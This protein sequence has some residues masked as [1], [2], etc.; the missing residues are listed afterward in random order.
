MD[1]VADLRRQRRAWWMSAGALRVGAAAAVL[2]AIL[3]ITAQEVAISRAGAAVDRL[4]G[5]AG[6]VNAAKAAEDK[7]AAIQTAK[8][9]AQR[10]MVW[11]ANQRIPGRAAVEL[12]AAISG[13]QDPV[14]RPVTL[15]AISVSHRANG[16]E[17]V[18]SGQAQSTGSRDPAAV[19]KGF[20]RELRLRMPVITAMVALPSK[21]EQ[22]VLPFT[23]RL[24]IQR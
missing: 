15:G 22:T 11:L 7:L 18:I 2:L 19:L 6:L 9:S 10:R 23:Y 4:Q 16:V 20:E 3:A 13:V 21:V 8:Q 14:D 17:A 24:A 5:G 12:L 1:V